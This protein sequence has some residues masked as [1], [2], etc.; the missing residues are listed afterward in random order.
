MTTPF[1]H[2][3]LLGVREHSAP[4][5]HDNTRSSVI[6][7]FISK[8][9]SNV[10]PLIL[11]THPLSFTFLPRCQYSVNP[12]DTDYILPFACDPVSRPGSATPAYHLLIYTRRTS[13]LHLRRLHYLARRLRLICLYRR[14]ANHYQ[15]AISTVRYIGRFVDFV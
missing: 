12:L 5:H 4:P 11:N 13:Y 8:H 1:Q 14:R 3:Y 7:F 10:Q 15:V 9:L 2:R 6:H